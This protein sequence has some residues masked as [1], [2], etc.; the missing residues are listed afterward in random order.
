MSS[1]VPQSLNRFNAL[2]NASG[3]GRRDLD[4]KITLSGEICPSQL[5]SQYQPGLLGPCAYRLWSI[6]WARFCFDLGSMPMPEMVN[7]C[8]TEVPQ[9]PFF[10]AGRGRS[11][12][13]TS[14]ITSSF[15]LP[16]SSSRSAVDFGSGSSKNCKVGSGLLGEGRL[17]G[18]R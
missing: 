8:D 4:S 2:M 14:N 3:K 11:C 7:L 5:T 9:S 17:W 16:L 12:A 15:P 1:C 18:W 10:S 13:G 6:M